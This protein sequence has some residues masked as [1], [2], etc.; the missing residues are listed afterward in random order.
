MMYTSLELKVLRLMHKFN[1]TNAEIIEKLNCS[2]AELL[3]VQSS[4]CAKLANLAYDL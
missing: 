1:K 4:L 2:E 3:E